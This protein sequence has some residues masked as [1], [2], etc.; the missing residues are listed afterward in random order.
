MTSRLTW[1]DHIEQIC[2]KARKL[3]GMLYRQFYSWA[4]SNTLLLIYRTC[5]RPH[6]DYACQLWNPNKGM[7]SL[8]AVQKFD[9]KVCLKQWDLNYDSMLQLLNLPHL[10]VR[11]KYL[12]LTTTY[13]IVSGHMHFR[14]SIFLQNNLFIRTSTLNFIRPF[15]HTN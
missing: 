4:D 9:C 7:Q 13:N 8:E 2:T 14:S 12:K 15:A 6:L 11:R 5:I 10:S 1:S 3:V